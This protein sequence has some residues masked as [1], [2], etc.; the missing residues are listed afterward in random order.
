MKANKEYKFNKD[1][2]QKVSDTKR[3]LDINKWFMPTQVAVKEAKAQN[4]IHFDLPGIKIEGYRLKDNIVSRC[5]LIDDLKYLDLL[6]ELL[7]LNQ[8]D[9]IGLNV[10]MNADVLNDLYRIDV[11]GP[12]VITL[13]T[14]HKIFIIDILQLGRFA[15][16]DRKLT[17]IFSKSKAT[18]VGFGVPTLI[19]YM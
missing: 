8:W 10:Q 2:E 1:E 4:T 14:V 16:L 3:A 6:D 19:N 9:M 5:I 12:S 13:G 18:F 7:L 17:E 11:F 15:D